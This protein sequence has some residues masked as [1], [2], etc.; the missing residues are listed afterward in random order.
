[1]NFLY[2]TRCSLSAEIATELCK[3]EFDYRLLLPRPTSQLMDYR[4]H[5]GTA[6]ARPD[7]HVVHPLRPRPH[8]LQPR[9]HLGAG[10]GREVLTHHSGLGTYKFCYCLYKEQSS[11][12]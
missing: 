9:H 3:F 8:H 7:R 12:D 4:P 6:A 1:M 10:E 11:K 5:S 2:V